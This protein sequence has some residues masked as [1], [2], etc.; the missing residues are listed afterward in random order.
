MIPTNNRLPSL[1]KG[2]SAWRIGLLSEIP[3]LTFLG[4]TTT[5]FCGSAPSPNCG[6]AALFR[7][8]PCRR[9]RAT[10]RPR[11]NL[12]RWAAPADRQIGGFNALRRRRDVTHLRSAAPGGGNGDAGAEAWCAPPFRDGQVG[13]VS[14]LRSEAKEN[15]HSERVLVEL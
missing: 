4:L 12:R 11:R 13:M 1:P 9:S 14:I 3:L 7:R 10:N 2:L 15:G 6:S 8:C 5:E